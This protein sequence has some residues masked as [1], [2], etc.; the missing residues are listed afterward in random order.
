MITEMTAML[1]KGAAQGAI[2]YFCH[3][4]YLIIGWENGLKDF[5]VL[6]YPHIKGA[7]NAPLQVCWYI[8]DNL[9]FGIP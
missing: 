7:R 1:L 8:W 6:K 2:A 5:Q 3:G 9:F 4:K